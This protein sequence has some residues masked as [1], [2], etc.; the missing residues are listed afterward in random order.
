MARGPAPPSS[1]ASHARPCGR[2]CGGTS[3]TAHPWPRLGKAT[4]REPRRGGIP[5]NGPPPREPT[6]P[7]PM[8]SN[9]MK[10]DLPAPIVSLH[11]ASM[12]APLRLLG[13]GAGSGT[14]GGLG[15]RQPERQSGP[16]DH[17]VQFY[18]DEVWLYRVV[19][20]L[21][22]ASQGRGEALAV[23]ATARP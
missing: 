22:V 13:M 9:S 23:V 12:N 11:A 17:R 8:A 7:S 6:G 21:F 15:E 20:E 16:F 5:L 19:G 3:P 14:G 10:T 2:S 1:S 18:E 4:C